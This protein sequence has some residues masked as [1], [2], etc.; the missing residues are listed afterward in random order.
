MP[1]QPATQHRSLRVPDEL[2][3]RMKRATSD[4]GTNVAEVTREFYEQY[5]RA[6]EDRYVGDSPRDDC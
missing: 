5:A 1:N 2:W 6:Y 3:E 4:Q